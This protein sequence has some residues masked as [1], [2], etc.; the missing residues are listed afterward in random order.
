[1]DRKLERAVQA[2]VRDIKNKKETAKSKTRTG[3]L[4]KS[5]EKEKRLVTTSEQSA[6][7]ISSRVNSCVIPRS[8][9]LR[10]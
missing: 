1:M 5:W 4:G 9:V 2:K 7:N 8:R 3:D 10:V 6:P